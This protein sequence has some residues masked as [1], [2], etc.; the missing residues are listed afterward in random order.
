MSWNVINKVQTGILRTTNQQ[1]ATGAGLLYEAP[2]ITIGSQGR[3][4][5]GGGVGSTVETTK[6]TGLAIR[7]FKLFNSAGS[8]MTVGIGFRLHNRYWRCGVTD[9][10]AFTDDTADAQ[11]T[12][13]S[14]VIIGANDADG[15]TTEFVIFSP[16]PFNWFSMNVETVEVNAA[17]DV[18]HVMQFSNAAGTGWT[19]IATT[20]SYR[21]T[22][23]LTNTVI[24][25]G[26]HE[27]AWP[28]N[29]AWGKVVSLGGIPP[30]N[31]AL[32]IETAQLDATDTAALAS[33]IEVGTMIFR[34]NVGAA[35]AWD[36]ADLIQF[37]QHEADAVVAFFSTADPLN[38]VYAEV[39]TF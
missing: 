39:T 30:G 5:A 6:M 31:Y 2:S 22:L 1:S 12:T 3:F 14:D 32:R 38:T 33:A 16:I 18:D 36:S 24:P 29:P 23:T 4:T 26:N 19:T 17:G 15:N 20:G 10:T 25:T 28:G 9:G 34:E 37:K 21:D 7:R 11:N 13:A 27:F 8:A 35:A